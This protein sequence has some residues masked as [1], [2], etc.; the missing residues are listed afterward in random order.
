MSA[1]GHK[2]TLRSD[3]S[4]AVFVVYSFE[5]VRDER[6]ITFRSFRRSP[7]ASAKSACRKGLAKR[8]NPTVVCSVPVS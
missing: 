7:T 2:R 3:W 1:L 5:L 8:G 6:R 4:G